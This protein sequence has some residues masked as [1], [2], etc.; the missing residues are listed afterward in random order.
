MLTDDNIYTGHIGYSDK[1]DGVEMI[2]EW[3]LGARH[4]AAWS[5][6]DII[7]DHVIYVKYNRPT[8]H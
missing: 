2:K 1:Q 5:K 4:M 3:N 6:A 8:L 7:Q